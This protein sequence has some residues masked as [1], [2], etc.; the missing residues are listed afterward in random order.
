[1]ILVLFSKIEEKQQV[2]E[3]KPKIDPGQSIFT[4]EIR[5]FF[6]ASENLLTQKKTE[7]S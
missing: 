7:I 1:M 3:Q 4:I 2:Q 6:V 5:I